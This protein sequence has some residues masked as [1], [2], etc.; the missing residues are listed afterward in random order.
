VPGLRNLAAPAV[1]AFVMF[2]LPDGMIG[3]AWPSI[4]AGLGLPLDRLGVL[5]V[6]GTVGYLL[7]SAASGLL[8]RRLGTGALVLAAGVIA[9]AGSALILASGVLAMLAGGVLV[10]GACGGVIDPSLSTLASMRGRHRLMNL[11][12]GGYGVGAA[13]GPGLVT[14]AIALGSW[15]LAYAGLA[16]CQVSVTCWWAVAAARSRDAAPSLPAAGAVSPVP[17]GGA[18]LPVPAGG[19]ALPV[20]AG[21][22]A[23]SLPAAGAVSPVPAGG[24]ALPAPAVAAALPAPAAAGALALPPLRRSAL[25][26]GLLAF[27][28]ASGLEISAGAW[29]ATYLR[30]HLGLS[31]LAAGLGVFCYWVSLTASRLAA[32]ALPHRWGPRRLAIAGCLVAGAGAALLWCWP[33][34]AAAIAGLVLL[35]CG[36][37][38]VFPALTSLTP[39]RVGTAWAPHLIGWQLGAGAVGAA[40]VSSVFGISLQRAG[41]Q[42]TGPLLTGLAVVVTGIAIALNRI[43]AHPALSVATTGGSW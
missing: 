39:E 18:A 9:L 29:A 30:G 4:R 10:L 26:L 33:Q 34:P 11:L 32:G 23:P 42:L 31:A 6:A 22:A 1:A 41:L 21:G 25:V 35:G 3:V 16:V 19:A 17:A 27:F 37:G 13:A 8:V 2:G 40:V 28:F 20:P 12:H 7:T 38:P 14:A 24:A 15:R 43:G 5:M 36:T